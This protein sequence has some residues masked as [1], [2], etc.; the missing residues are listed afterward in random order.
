MLTVVLLVRWLHSQLVF[1]LSVGV[2]LFAIWSGSDWSLFQLWDDSLLT[3]G[4]AFVTATFDSL[5]ED[6][7][8]WFLMHFVTGS[9]KDVLESVAVGHWLRV[10]V[11]ALSHW[12]LALAA[13]L[14]FP[15]CRTCLVN[16][17][18]FKYRY[19]AIV[20]CKTAAWNHAEVGLRSY[21]IFIYSVYHKFPMSFGC[22]WIFFDCVSNNTLILL[23]KLSFRVLVKVQT[24]F[25]FF[26]IWISTFRRTALGW[27]SHR[28]LGAT[29][30]SVLM[31]QHAFQLLDWVVSFEVC[32]KR[33]SLLDVK[34]CS[35]WLNVK[36]N[37]PLTIQH[38]V[39][40]F[41]KQRLLFYHVTDVVF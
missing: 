32:H 33:L 39:L 27:D 2:V 1:S 11:W 14:L 10:A 12:W 19:L 38:A 18:N 8:F 15:E 28:C 9:A 21:F 17:V 40:L 5:V 3:W 37:N 24:S 23:K 34:W 13:Q 7:D 6:T 16:L 26:N 22:F 31:D 41:T 36:L 30:S 35:D 20:F 29:H 4:L 25:I